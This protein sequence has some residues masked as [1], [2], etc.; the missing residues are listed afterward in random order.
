MKDSID[1]HILPHTHL[2]ATFDTHKGAYL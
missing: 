2:Q 1:V